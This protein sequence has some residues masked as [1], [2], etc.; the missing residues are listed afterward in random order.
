MKEGCTKYSAI[1]NWTNYEPWQLTEKERLEMVQFSSLFSFLYIL[2]CFGLFLFKATECLLQVLQSP[3][4]DILAKLGVSWTICVNVAPPNLGFLYINFPISY[5]VLGRGD[6][7]EARWRRLLKLS[8][9]LHLPLVQATFQWTT[10]VSLVITRVF[11]PFAAGPQC[12]LC[13]NV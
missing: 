13:P 11:M 5:P 1:K 4:Q 10:K 2:L 12:T 8:N 7:F 9:S 3:I 6:G